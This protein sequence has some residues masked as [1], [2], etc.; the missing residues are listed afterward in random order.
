MRKPKPQSSF[1]PVL[2]VMTCVFLLIAG[3]FGLGTVHLRK[4]IARAAAETRALEN[5]LAGIRLAEIRLTGEIAI[6]RNPSRLREKN[7]E[8]VLG[9]RPPFERQIVR[10]GVES[11]ERFAE[12]RWNEMTAVRQPT[13]FAFNLYES[14]Q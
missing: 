5:R 13:Y 11:Q 6:A 10:V 7:E 9:L 8:F 4:D 3:V 1:F 2:G 12:L 14:N